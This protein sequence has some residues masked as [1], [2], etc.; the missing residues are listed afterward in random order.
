MIVTNNIYEARHLSK[1][2]LKYGCLVVLLSSLI[3]A[4]LALNRSFFTFGSETD[5]LARNI[6]EAQRLLDGKPLHLLFHPPFYSFVLALCQALFRDW[7]TTG[8]IVSWTSSIVVLVTSFVFFYHL[9]GRYAAW[10]S[11]AGLLSSRLFITYSCLATQDL[12][13]LAVYCSCFF[14]SILA[15]EARS[16]KLWVLTGVAVGLA[17]LT[18]SNSL[19]LLLLLAFPW[20]QALPFRTRVEHFAC[21]LVA[22]LIVLGSWGI[23]AKLI[24]SPFAP[25]LGHVNLAMRY[26]PTGG[27]PFTVESRRALVEKFTSYKDVFMYD[28]QHMA[29]TYIKD[30]FK[31]L[32]VHLLSTKLLT[33]PLH[34]FALPG[35]FLLFFAT[36]NPFATLFLIATLAQIALLNF[37]EYQP[38]FYLFL[39]PILSAGVGLCALEIR[40]AI[41]KGWKQGAALIL[42]LPLLI[43]GLNKSLKGAY[44][45]LHSQDDELIEAVA[46]V[47]KLVDPNGLI[48]SIKPHL[49]FYVGTRRAKLP[50]FNH[51]D[52]LRAWLESQKAMGLI[53]VYF[54]SSER[55]LRPQLSALISPETAPG[56]LE[57]LAKSL[58]SDGWILYRFIPCS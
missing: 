3:F 55:H 50:D 14:L 2:E 4:V 46:E 22:C 19:T 1:R 24:G 16:K 40:R 56:W 58:D 57:P 7:F 27:D 41:P 33:F 43:V 20:V 30:F 10:G 47:G 29:A 45:Q 54:G 36:R 18:R 26:F 28:P 12:F 49:P 21:I 6:V 39:V 31:M 48:V 51:S 42:L 52:D 11:L 44:K 32:R 17:L 25:Q 34:L 8:L 37:K 13:F 23:T 15:M 53:Y 5:Y 35:V 9:G 38:R